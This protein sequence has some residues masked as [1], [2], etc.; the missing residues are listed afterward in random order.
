MTAQFG[1]NR[2]LAV[3]QPAPTQLGQGLSR[4][5]AGFAGSLAAGVSGIVAA[6]VAG[7]CLHSLTSSRC[8]RMRHPEH[9]CSNVIVVMWL[10][11]NLPVLSRTCTAAQHCRGPRSLNGYCCLAKRALTCS[12][13]R[14]QWRAG[15]DWQG[16]AGR[17]GPAL[18]GGSGPGVFP[19]CCPRLIDRHCSNLCH[20]P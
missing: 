10:R 11:Y 5:L 15:G 20:S 7:T 8:R 3:R 13:Q 12:L 19:V 9:C 1:G 2:A 16:P 4:G 6:P 18:V 14:W 17:C